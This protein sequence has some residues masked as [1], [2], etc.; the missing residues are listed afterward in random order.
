MPNLINVRM[1]SVES[2]ITEVRPAF[3]SSIRTYGSLPFGDSDNDPA[4]T[5]RQ[6]RKA[7]AGFE[8]GDKR[9]P[10]VRSSHICISI[11]Y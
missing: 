8:F 2:L 11:D 6:V 4:C 7:E 9:G 10:G 3:S 1:I 5:V